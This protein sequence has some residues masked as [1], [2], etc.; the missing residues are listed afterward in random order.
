MKINIAIG[1]SV[2]AY[3]RIII[4]EFFNNPELTGRV[5]YS[6]TDSIFCDKELPSRYIGTS[7]GKM[8]L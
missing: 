8:N 5:Y 6:D 4:S 2:T 1:L 7:L 3:A